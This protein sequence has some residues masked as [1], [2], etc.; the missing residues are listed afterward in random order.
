[1]RRSLLRLLDFLVF[2]AFCVGMVLLIR[3]HLGQKEKV[4][5]EG[6]KGPLWEILPNGESH[7]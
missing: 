2:V 5:V 4:V 6:R 3:N 7:R 1:M